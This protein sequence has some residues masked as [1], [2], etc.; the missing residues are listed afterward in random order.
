[1]S[2]VLALVLACT[3]TPHADSAANG[4]DTAGDSAEAAGFSVSGQ[5]LDLD[6]QPVV[7]V[8]VT[9]STEYCIPDRTAEDGSF[10]V[11][12][13]DAGDKRLITYG[14]TAENG[15]FASVVFPFEASDTVTFDDPVLAPALTETWPLDPTIDQQIETDDGLSLTISAD[16]LSLAPFAPEELQVA[17]VPVART[18]PMVPEGVTLL[19]VFVLH[20]IQSTL[21]PPAPVAFPGNTEL[22]EGQAVAFWSLDYDTGLMAQVAT[23][24]VDAEGR[25][26]TA[27][28][29]GLVELTW[30]GV[31]LLEN[32]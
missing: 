7:D 12:D 32:R 4:E 26:V 24:T 31:A 27:D 18:P 6:D 17:R 28:G 22:S 25:P 29:E 13:V 10:T 11:G 2:S 15:L 9:V 19:D 5:V 23:G 1:M 14:E 8:F 30:V 21:D 20:P 16:S 3:G